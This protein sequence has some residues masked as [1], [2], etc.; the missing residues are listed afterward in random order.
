[1]T[2]RL[3][4]KALFKQ[5]G[6]AKRLHFIPL[7]QPSLEPPVAAP[8]PSPALPQ[9]LPPLPSA[10]AASLLRHHCCPSRS[11]RHQPLPWLLYF[12]RRPFPGPVWSHSRVP[13]S[14]AVSSGSAEFAAPKA[15]PIAVIVPWST[16]VSRALVRPVSVHTALPRC[17]FLTIAMVRT[18]GGSRLR[19]GSDSALPSKSSRLQFQLQSQSQSQSQSLRSLRDSGG[20]RPGWDPGPLHQYL[21]GDPRG[22]GPPS[23]PVHQDQGSP[24]HLGPSRDLHRQQRRRPHRLN[25]RLPRG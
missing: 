3:P 19:L 17:P 22:P 23:G 9:P 16:L 20:T 12:A 5:R 21:R 1:M 8:Q 6:R 10:S 13:Q 18:R 4:L 2:L 24:H 25:Y 14:S 7:P 11:R 15:I